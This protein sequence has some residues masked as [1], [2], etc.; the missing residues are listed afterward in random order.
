VVID[1]HCFQFTQAFQGLDWE[2]TGISVKK[3]SASLDIHAQI[4][5]KS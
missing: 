5:R 4:A 1:P 3:M 2:K